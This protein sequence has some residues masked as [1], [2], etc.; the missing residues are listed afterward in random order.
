MI[1]SSTDWRTAAET[2]LRDAARAL[3]CGPVPKECSLAVPTP[4][5]RPGISR[6]TEVDIKAVESLGRAVI[7]LARADLTELQRDLV[8]DRAIDRS[9][10]EIQSRNPGVPDSTLRWYHNDALQKI[11]RALRKLKK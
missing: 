7:A 2:T 3:R 8:W 6:S 1:F 9:W 10:K 11:A 5:G 4:I